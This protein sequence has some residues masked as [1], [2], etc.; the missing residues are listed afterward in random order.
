MAT[1]DSHVEVVSAT[2]AS[3]QSRTFASDSLTVA[4]SKTTSLTLTF[5]S[6]SGQ[7]NDGGQTLLAPAAGGGT[8]TLALSAGVPGFFDESISFT[9]VKSIHL[10]NL[11]TTAS[12]LISGAFWNTVCGT[13]AVSQALKPGCFVSVNNIAGWTSGNLVVT[14]SHASNVGSILA[15]YS[16]VE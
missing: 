11:S 2:A 10:A 8:A 4:P 13:S 14:N 5:G 3:T 6:G 12:A 9:S 1:P 15:K 7:V 16:G